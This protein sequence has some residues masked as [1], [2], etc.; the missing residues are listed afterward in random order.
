M[1]FLLSLFIFAVPAFAQ[2]EEEPIKRINTEVIINEITPKLDLSTRQVKRIRKELEKTSKKFDK[3]MKS[4]EKNI[5]EEQKWHQ[6]AA[7]NKAEM[8]ELSSGIIEIVTSQLDDQQQVLFEKF[9]EEK[10]KPVHPEFAERQEKEEAAA[11]EGTSNDAVQQPVVEEAK[12]VAEKKKRVVLKKKNRRKKAAGSS[13]L[14]PPGSKR[15]MKPKVSKKAE[16]DL[17]STV[18]PPQASPAPAVSPAPNAESDPLGS[19]DPLK[20]PSGN[21]PASAGSA[22]PSL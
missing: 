7:A 3:S 14:V 19:D 15:S 10:A 8:K 12:T 16:T 18:L 5:A 21:K 11:K 1:Y 2:Q 6:K 4:Y 13:S 22:V 20:M 17:P 9:L